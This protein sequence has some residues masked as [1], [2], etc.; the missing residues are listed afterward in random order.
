MTN[1][2]HNLVK[3]SKLGGCNSGAVAIVFF[4]VGVRNLPLQRAFPLP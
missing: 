2:T 3:S 4:L 1:S